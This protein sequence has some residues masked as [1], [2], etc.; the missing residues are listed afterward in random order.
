MDRQ[1][2]E[3][4]QE[5]A[6]TGSIRQTAEAVG[7]SPTAVTRQLD[8]LERNFGS[9]LVERTPR[10]VRLTAA[11]E[12][13]AAKSRDIARELTLTH[14]MIDDLKGLRRGHASIH[15][16]GAA[17]S[18]IL[19]PALSEFALLYPGISV[20][21]SVTSA[22]G[23]LD[24][25]AMGATDLA[26]TM[27]APADSRIL[28]RY[29][30]PVRHEPVMAPD[31]PLA[32]REAIGIAQM[33][34]HRLALPDRGFGVRRAFD[35]LMRAQGIDRFEPAFTTSSMELQKDL[36]RRG[37]AVLILPRM[38]VRH[39]LDAGTLIA[40]PFEPRARIET[41][42]ELGHSVAHHQSMAARRLIDFLEAF[43]RCHHG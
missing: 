37:A 43:L 22:Q 42:L 1:A 5:L 23:A 7:V 4:F 12:M 16:N 15:V 29:R 9:P 30:G 39:D 11:G 3:L 20:E 40:R 27:F 33:A 41:L 28:T 35:R 18:S 32:A 6:R 19:G 8:K 14:Q 2:I 21:V 17:I 26:V 24:A 25:V 34:E 10:G 38:A 36:A 13:L 31:H